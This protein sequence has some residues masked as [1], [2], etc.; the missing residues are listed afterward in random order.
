MLKAHILYQKQ[1]H[2]SPRAVER[3]CARMYDS[4]EDL[5][6]LYSCDSWPE[7]RT[8]VLGACCCTHV[9]TCACEHRDSA[10]LLCTSSCFTRDAAVAAMRALRLDSASMVVRAMTSAS[11]NTAL[12]AGMRPRGGARARVELRIAHA[13]N[14][15]HLGWGI[16]AL[17]QVGDR[18]CARSCTTRYVAPKAATA[19]WV[20]IRDMP[21]GT[22]DEGVNE[23]RV[24]PLEPF[25][26]THTHARACARACARGRA[27]GGLLC[28]H[29][30]GALVGQ[31]MPRTR[32]SPA[33]A[34]C[35]E[36]YWS[37]PRPTSAGTWAAAW[38]CQSPGTS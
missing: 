5:D 2:K 16:Q 17:L 4:P 15:D 10:E 9:R 34:Q 12:R 25:T 32:Q 21:A 8:E 35:P 36:R 33:C 22:H 26:H 30:P 13:P 31:P 24:Q 37:P 19:L 3:R 38:L 7:K 11:R 28:V 1:I 27:T 29:T 20:H 14:R 23:T 18:D 6:M